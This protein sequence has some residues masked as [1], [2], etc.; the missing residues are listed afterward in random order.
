MVFIIP[1]K[2]KTVTSDWDVFSRLTNRCINSIC[3]QSNTDFKILIPCH[4]IPDTEFSN[5]PRVEFLRMEFSPPALNNNEDLW[6]LRADKGRKIKFA[7]D[8][9]IKMGASYVMT[10][11]SDDCISNKICKFVNKNGSD[12]ISGWHVK[13][14]Y[15]YPEGKRYLYLNIKNF[16]TICGTCVIIKPEL[17]DLMYGKNFWFDHERTNFENG[18]SLLPLPFPGAIYSMLNGINI[19]LDV[20]EMKK[21]TKFNPYSSEAIKTLFRRLAKY[22]LLPLAFVKK[23]FS[24][25]DV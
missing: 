8:H 17:I 22:R 15:L 21:R 12:S 4:E 25:Y 9:A 13:K 10:V 11:D 23:E 14:G 2:S 20:K 18:L 24:I 19:R 3:N 6:K 7:A 16:H 5:D 1:V